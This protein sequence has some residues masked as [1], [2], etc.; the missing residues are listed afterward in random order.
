MKDLAQ[1]ISCRLPNAYKGE[2][3]TRL[4]QMR[5]CATRQ[6]KM[7]ESCEMF[8]TDWILGNRS[9]LLTVAIFTRNHFLVNNKTENI[10]RGSEGVV[11]ED[12]R[13]NKAAIPP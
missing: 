9:P 3:A 4:G 12:R 6:A 2:K 11:G 8:L 10:K 13:N 5:N 1:D 7:L